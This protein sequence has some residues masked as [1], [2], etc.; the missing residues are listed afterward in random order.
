[1]ADPRSNI[2]SPPG[3]PIIGNLLNVQNEVPVKGLENVIDR[4]GPIVKLNF[5]GRER[6]TIASAELLEELCDEKR[7][8]KTPGDGLAS[9]SRS[10][11]SGKASVASHSG[12]FSAPSEDDMDWQQ[13]HRNLM[14]AF[15]P[16]SIQTM[17]GEM[18]RRKDRS[19]TFLA[20]VL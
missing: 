12:L 1:M 18:V 2:P 15:G 6:I 11:G 17:F 5:L 9:L 8:W 20:D 14:P 7:F 4:Y 16:I 19:A 10:S 13:A 3:L